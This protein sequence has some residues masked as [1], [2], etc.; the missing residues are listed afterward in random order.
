MSTSFLVPGARPAQGDAPPPGPLLR[1]VHIPLLAR[2]LGGYSSGELYWSL[3]DTVDAISPGVYL[4]TDPQGRIVW[5][6]KAAG[7]RG[8]AGRIRKHLAESWK[9]AVFHRVWVA[10]ACD[11]ISR[12]ALEAAEGWAADALAMRTRMP[13]RAWPLSTNWLSLIGLQSVA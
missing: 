10:P 13:H 6:G 12:S 9:R 1:P 5:L 2:A 11:Q 7:G 4:V 8:V 3:V